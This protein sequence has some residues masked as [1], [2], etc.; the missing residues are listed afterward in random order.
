MTFRPIHRS[1]KLSVYIIESKLSLRLMSDIK[2]GIV[3]VETVK[4][5]YMSKKKRRGSSVCRCDERLSV[6]L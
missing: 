4:E 3:T 5:N 6:V 1:S 2:I